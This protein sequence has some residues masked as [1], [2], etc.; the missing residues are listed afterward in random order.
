MAARLA[1]D[2]AVMPVVIRRIALS[3]PAWFAD[4]CY[5][6]RKSGLMQISNN[7]VKSSVLFVLAACAL[8]PVFP[9]G[10]AFAA[11]PERL[12]KIV[13]PFAPGGGTDVV[14][15]TLAQEMSKDLVVSVIIENKP[16]AG[17]I[18]GTQSV[19]TSAPAG[20][21][22]LMGTFANAVNPSLQAKLPYDAHAD[23][24]AAGPIPP[25]LQPVVVSTPAPLKTHAPLIP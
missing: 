8:L 13:V 25:S 19:A 11:Y 16:A 15:R 22:L 4:A 5:S 12:V 23:F 18:I 7:A 14:A 3:G 20:Y 2:A 21:T 24:A 10:E 9:S 17:T 6:H 1:R